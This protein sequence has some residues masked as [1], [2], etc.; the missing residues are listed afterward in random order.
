MNVAVHG[1]TKLHKSA[2]NLI[3]KFVKLAVYTFAYNGLTSVFFD[4][5]KTKR[6][7]TEIT[8]IC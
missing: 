2:K 8:C 6:P 1:G 7:E 4:Y 3:K 5:K